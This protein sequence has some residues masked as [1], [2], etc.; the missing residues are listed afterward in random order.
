MDNY[1]NSNSDLNSNL[2]P[3]FNSDN[4]MT[5]ENNFQ[6][7]KQKLQESVKEYLELD[8]QVDAINKVLRDKRKR[9]KDL[10]EFILSCMKQ[11]EI[12][13]M[14][15]KN[16]K[17]IYNITNSKAPLNKNNLTKALGNY[18]NDENR[19]NEATNYVMEN[20]ERIQ[21]VNLKRMKIKNQTPN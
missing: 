8:D 10:T 7:Y 21:K 4:N 19:G 1:L 11:F 16:G 12:N 17:L 9:R 3:D 18:F 5:D 2:N 14:N 13:N 6:I 15:T 20:R